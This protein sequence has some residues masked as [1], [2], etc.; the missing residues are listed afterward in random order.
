LTNT[1]EK[2]KTE[3]ETLETEINNYGMLAKAQKKN[4]R[5]Q[6]SLLL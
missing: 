1:V 2:D 5:R 6:K 3:Q 4:E